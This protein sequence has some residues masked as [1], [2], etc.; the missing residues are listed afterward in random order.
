MAPAHK[1]NTQRIPACLAVAVKWSWQTPVTLNDTIPIWHAHTTSAT[2]PSSSL[3]LR[4]KSERHLK[5]NEGLR[6]IHLRCKYFLEACCVLP[7]SL[8]LLLFFTGSSPHGLCLLSV[9][10]HCLTIFS[11]SK[12]ESVRMCES[13]QVNN[14]Q[15]HVCVC[16]STWISSSPFTKIKLTV[17]FWILCASPPLPYVLYQ[18]C[19]VCTHCIHCH[20]VLSRLLANTQISTQP[21]SR[22]SIYPLRS[23]NSWSHVFFETSNLLW[24]S[25]MQIPTAS[26]LCAQLALVSSYGNVDN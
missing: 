19:L 17:S 10:D 15:R 8:L 2:L 21:L 25:F 20:Q 26:S 13:C 22:L 16:V 18:Y 12:T 23:L 3:L 14:V 7:C 24:L 6:D 5:K 4:W 1:P 11:L 9:R